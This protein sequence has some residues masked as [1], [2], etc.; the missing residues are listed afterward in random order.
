MKDW[1]DQT[2]WLDGNER[3]EE[4]HNFDQEQEMAF[5][6]ATK[7][8]HN[9]VMLE[10]Q[11]WNAEMREQHEVKQDKYF[12][13]QL[14]LEAEKNKTAEILT[15]WKEKRD[16]EVAK[17]DADYLEHLGNVTLGV[18]YKMWYDQALAMDKERRARFHKMVSCNC[19]FCRR[20]FRWNLCSPIQFSCGQ[21]CSLECTL[22]HS[23]FP[24]LI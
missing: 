4:A 20:H 5:Q 1:Y 12:A 13:Y 2:D 24:V 16:A 6:E 3:L 14:R 10:R 8:L 9:K 11:D 22:S 21:R 17:I 19:R 18:D 15:Q 23:S 7:E